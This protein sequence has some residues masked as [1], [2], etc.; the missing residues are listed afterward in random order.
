MWSLSIPL[1]WS[2]DSGYLSFINLKTLSFKSFPSIICFL[3][4]SIKL[5]N[6]NLI[7]QKTFVTLT[8]GYQK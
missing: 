4:F 6:I 7:K 1:N 5:G 8:F 3:Y 2:I